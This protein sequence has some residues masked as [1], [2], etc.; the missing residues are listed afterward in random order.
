M[1]AN[2]V[3]RMQRVVAHLDYAGGHPPVVIPAEARQM[4]VLGSIEEIDHEPRP[5]ELFLAWLSAIRARWSQ[6]TFYL[7]SPDS[8]R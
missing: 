4:P 1:S 8:W 2:A 6:L 7:L 3:V 5:A